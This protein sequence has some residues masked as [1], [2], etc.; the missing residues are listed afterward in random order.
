MQCPPGLMT[1]T[2]PQD[3]MS[4]PQGRPRT[5]PLSLS[6][7]PGTEL[8]PHRL[9]GWELGHRLP[10]Q[11]ELEFPSP[12]PK[13]PKRQRPQHQGDRHK[14]GAEHPAGPHPK[15][16]V[17][18]MAPGVS[19]A[20]SGGWEPSPLQRT[21]LGTVP[22]LEGAAWCWAWGA[23]ASWGHTSVACG[24]RVRACSQGGPRIPKG[25]PEKTADLRWTLAH[26]TQH[27]SQ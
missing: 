4:T 21:S 18:G 12:Q 7:P 10:G 19:Q 22:T 16:L 17:Q 24:P 1:V 9:L 20:F 2:R 27:R 13:T 3:G 25:P 26:C 23:G 15:E 6:P 14:P 8:S 5:P 11:Q